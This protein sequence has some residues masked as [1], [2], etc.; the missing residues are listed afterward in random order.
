MERH[1]GEPEPQD[2][3]RSPLFTTLTQTHGSITFSHDFHSSSKPQKCSVQSV[4]FSHSVESDSLWL[5]RLQHASLP[6]PSPT[7]R[8]YSNSHPLSQIPS[9]H[10]ILCHPLF[11]SPS[12]FP[13]ITVFSNELVICTKWP[14]PIH[15][16]RKE[17]FLSKGS[18]LMPSWSTHRT[19]DW[20]N[21]K[22]V[23]SEVSQSCPTLCDPMDCSLPGSS[24]H[25]I[26]QA[27]VLEWIAISFS[28]GSSRPRDRTQVS[29]IVDRRFTV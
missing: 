16:C 2:L 9:N 18:N 14:V 27:I 17:N 4:Q 26:F 5:H 20:A 3:L 19:K 8:A 22:K 10:L 25:G 11:L 1:G 24:V 28:R 13:S 21:T 7:P 29:R 15:N 23:E 6:C 12:I